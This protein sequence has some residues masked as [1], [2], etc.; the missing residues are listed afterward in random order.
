MVKYKVKPNKIIACVA[1]IAGFILLTQLLACRTGSDNTSGRDIYWFTQPPEIFHTND[2]ERAQKEIPF[3]IILPEYLPDE[4]D[5]HPEMIEGPIKGIYPDDETSVRLRYS[6]K[7]G[8]KN[9]VFIEELNWPV[10]VRPPDS[11]S[12]YLDINGIR[13]LETETES[14]LFTSSGTEYIPGLRYTWNL[15][16]VHFEVTVDE[17]GRSEARK[18]I[19]SMI[20]QMD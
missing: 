1:L 13:V 17:Y 7:D 10:I 15:G 19:I 16:G 8:D 18:I 5:P 6:E 4:L 20:N 2:L 11:E 14:M 3:T 12:T 9:L